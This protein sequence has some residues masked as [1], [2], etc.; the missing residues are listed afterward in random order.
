MFIRLLAFLCLVSIPVTAEEVVIGLSQ[1]EVAI[2]ATFDGDDILVF[3][4]VKREDAIDTENPLQVVISVA[5]PSKPI[6]V[7]RKERRFGLW[8]NTDAVDVDEAP[9]FYAVATSAP[10][11]DVLSEVDDLRH[12]I[13][14]PRAIRSVGAPMNVEDP[15]NFTE[16]LIRVRE[17]NN[18]YQTNIGGVGF[19]QQTLFRSY[20]ELPSNLTEGEYE[21]RIFLTR[22]GSVVSDYA[23]TISVKKVGL[24]RFLYNLAHTKPLI[25]GLMS[26]AIAIFAG[27]G[28]SAIFQ[29]FRR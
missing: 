29:A 13:T 8:V 12:R 22:D 25:Y 19:D 11:E 20:F 6:T 26:L 3:G 27:W 15:E 23:T 16:A 28:A 21:T 10:I 4:A 1:N 17:K 2:T 24:E 5:G 18:L 7:R 9:S 14:I